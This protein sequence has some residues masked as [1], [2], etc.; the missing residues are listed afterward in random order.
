[1][2]SDLQAGV[3]NGQVVIRSKGGHGE[4]MS[5]LRNEKGR[6]QAADGAHDDRVMAYAIGWRMREFASFGSID[7]TKPLVYPSFAGGGDRRPSPDSVA[8]R[9][10]SFS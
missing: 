8:Y 1:M 5:F 10:R 6:A 9:Y 7:V 4:M 2:L 3:R